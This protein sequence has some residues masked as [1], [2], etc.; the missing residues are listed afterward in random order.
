MT[1]TLQNK[2]EDQ[3]HLE[4]PKEL[5]AKIIAETKAL[6]EKFGVAEE[7]KKKKGLFEFERELKWINIVFITL[8]QVLG[9]Y[10]FLTYPYLQQWKAFAR[11]K[12]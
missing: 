4:C 3:P 9:I 2:Y 8:H 10:F 6:N 12:L 7:I 11:S 5:Q 1:S